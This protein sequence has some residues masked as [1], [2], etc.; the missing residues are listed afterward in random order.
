MLARKPSPLSVEDKLAHFLWFA[1][2]GPPP[3]RQRARGCLAQI[4]KHLGVVAVL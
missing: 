2:A 3:P 1:R 4:A